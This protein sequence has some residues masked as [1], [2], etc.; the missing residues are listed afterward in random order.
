MP[1]VM[2][3]LKVRLQFDEEVDGVAVPNSESLMP[4][5]T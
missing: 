3:A 4:K 2:G 1:Y 5:M